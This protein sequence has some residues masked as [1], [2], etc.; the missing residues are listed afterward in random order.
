METIGGAYAGKSMVID[1]NKSVIVSGGFGNIT[2]FDAGPGVFNMTSKGATDIYVT[3][4]DTSGNFKWAKQVGGVESDD[5][6]SI[7]IAR[8]GDLFLLGYFK[9]LLILIR[10]RQCII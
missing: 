7:Q 9:A 1:S 3:E 5:V 10:E 8:N 6:Y 2:D 4:Y